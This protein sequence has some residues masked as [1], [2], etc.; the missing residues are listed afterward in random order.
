MYTI[1]KLLDNLNEY[2]NDIKLFSIAKLVVSTSHGLYQY[3]N[4]MHIILDK[5]NTGAL[6]FN[7]TFHKVGTVT[8]QT[9]RNKEHLYYYM[10]GK[11]LPTSK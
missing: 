1:W 8:C 5:A 2:R 9:T 6:R 7:A 4:L 3:Q 11:H 10:P